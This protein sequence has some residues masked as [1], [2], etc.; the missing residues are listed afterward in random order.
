LHPRRKRL[1]K[2]APFDN[3]R[4]LIPTLCLGLGILVLFG[5]YVVQNAILSNIKY[6]IHKLSL[7]NKNLIKKNGELQ[8]AVA[9]HGSVGRIERLYRMKYGYLPVASTFRIKTLILPPISAHVR[10]QMAENEKLVSK[11]AEIK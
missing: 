4:A 2:R 10:R 5:T 1:K 11:K 7:D 9:R 6:K 8:I 3:L